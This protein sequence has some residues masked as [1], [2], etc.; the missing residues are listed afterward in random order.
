M[1]MKE[2]LTVGV[3]LV[4]VELISAIVSYG[5]DTMKMLMRKSEPLFH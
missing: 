2:L 1:A 3:G 5:S 4:E